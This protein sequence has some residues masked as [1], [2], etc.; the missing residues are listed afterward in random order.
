MAVLARYDPLVDDV[1][2][3]HAACSRPLPTIVRVNPIK[4]T[5]TRVIAALDEEGIESQKRAWHD[6]LLGLDTDS[7]GTTWPY[8]LGWIH[9]QEEVSALPVTVL[10]PDDGDRIW[11]ACAAPGS[12]TTQL[13]AAMHDSGLVVANDDTLGRL[14]ALRSN[15]ERLGITNVAVTNQDARHYSLNP[16]EFDTFDHALVDAPCSGEGTLRKNPG[17]LSEWDESQR[18]SLSRVQTDI[19]QR[20]IQVTRS[21]GTVVYATC[22]FAPEENEAVLDRVLTTED[23]RVVEFDCPLDAS[24]GVSEWRGTSFDKS[25]QHARRIWPHHNDTGGFFCAKLVVDR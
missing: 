16:F 14:P 3:L 15:T 11:D 18:P 20:A 4:S 1:D 10:A 24:P 19:L 8:F 21:G 9:G 17:A 6:G 12:K 2:A 13:A 22:T 23:C 25:V 5:V 7:P